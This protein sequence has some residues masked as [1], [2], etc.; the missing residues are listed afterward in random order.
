M[1]ATLN[2]RWIASLEESQEFGH[3]RLVHCLAE[4]EGVYGFGGAR[5]Q[6]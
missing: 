4:Q 2:A 6:R 5:C 3:D 1:G